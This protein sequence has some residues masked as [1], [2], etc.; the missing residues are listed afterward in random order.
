M[1]IQLDTGM[2]TIKVEESVNF[3][4]LIET[5]DRLLPKGEWKKFKLETQT[6]I[7]NWGNPIIIREY[8]YSRPFQPYWTSPGTSPFYAGDTHTIS[9]DAADF[10]LTGTAG[11]HNIETSATA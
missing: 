7:T 10:T 2:K 4:E 6:T 5:L 9:T 8:P 3:G 11:I 1:K